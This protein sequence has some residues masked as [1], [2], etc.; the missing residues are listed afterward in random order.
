MDVI[1]GQITRSVLSDRV[2]FCCLLSACASLVVVVGGVRCLLKTSSIFITPAARSSA[3][4]SHVCVRCSR[5]II[6]QM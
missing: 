1:N 2:L 5:Y 6:Q 3:P 4:A